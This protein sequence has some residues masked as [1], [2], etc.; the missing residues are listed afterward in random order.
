M[1]FD[2]TG[3]LTVGKPAVQQLVFIH[4]GMP[5][6]PEQ[7]HNTSSTTTATSSTSNGQPSCCST[8]SSPQKPAP[9]N[10]GSS[11]AGCGSGC[12]CGSSCGC[13]SKKGGCGCARS[14]QQQ[15]PGKGKPGF[16]QKKPCCAGK[17]QPVAAA[18]GSVTQS[19]PPSPFAAEGVQHPEQQQQQ[20]KEKEPQGL[21]NGS[22][23]CSLP[24]KQQQQQ[25]STHSMAAASTAAVAVPPLQPPQQLQQPQ[26]L[27]L[28]MLAAVEARSEHPLA[29]AV[30]SYAEKQGVT[31]D[32][33][34][35]TIESFHSQTGRGVRCSV[36]PA[37]GSNGS[38]GGSSAAPVDVIVGNVAWLQ[39]CGVGLSAAAR[40]QRADMEAGGATV[41]AAAI[42]S[43]AVALLGIADSMK[44][45]APAVLRLLQQRGMQCWMITGD[46]R[47]V[48]YIAKQADMCA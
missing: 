42:N 32:E 7:Q 6:V 25:G 15:S 37:A 11:S 4:D 46:S 21:A 19:G 16:A 38:S 27:M 35:C 33:L 26:R 41:V 20:G 48:E 5:E 10:N 12:K 39:E 36:I 3:T 29:K 9:R 1:V 30:V 13:S 40:Q 14:S 2:K 28:A 23:C 34:Q 43:K 22:A 45:E 44:P 17:V 24:A 31:P 47:W 18:Q 8:G